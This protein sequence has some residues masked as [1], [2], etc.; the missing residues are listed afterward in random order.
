MNGRID[1]DQLVEGVLISTCVGI[2]FYGSVVAN[3]VEFF[4]AA[5]VG[6]VEDGV[7]LVYNALETIL[8]IAFR[9]IAGCFRFPFGRLVSVDLNLF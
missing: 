9:L 2:Q 4:L 8:K 5:L 6:V 1:L 3:V 7:L